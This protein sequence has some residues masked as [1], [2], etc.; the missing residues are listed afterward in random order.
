MDIKS[1][2]ESLERVDAIE[3]LLTF[4][5][6][7]GPSNFISN[8]LE[9][10]SRFSEGR[11]AFYNSDYE[12]AA[13][14]FH[15]LDEGLPGHDW[16]LTPAKINETFSWLR[17][18]KFTEYVQQYEPLATQNKVYGVILWN[19]A[20]AYCRLE[21]MDKAEECLKKWL[22]SSSPP[23]LGKGYLLL[24]ILQ[25]HNGKID[26][27]ISSFHTALKV[28]KLFCIQA[29]ERHLGPETAEAVPEAETTLREPTKIEPQIVAKDEVL[30]ALQEFL[31]PRAPGK[32][33]QVAQQLSE[34]EYQSGYVAALE[35]FG[36]GDI[37]EALR[38]IDSLIKG[39]RERGA[40]FWAKAACLLAKREW[41]DSIALIEDQ[42]GD[43]DISEGV[44]WN[45]TC[46]YF[47]LGK[48][49]LALRTITKCT[50][51]VYRTS[52]WAWLIQGLLAHL[53][54]EGGLR[55]D[56]LKEAIKISPKQLV[57]YVGLLKQIGSDLEGLP[58][59]EEPQILGV[60][61]EHLVTKYD[62]IAKNARILLNKGKNLEA[63]KEFVQLSPESTADIPEIGD[64]TFKPVILP[65]CPAEL[66]D[67]RDIF[68]FGVAAFQRKAYE[69][70][71]QRFED[72][73]LKTDRSYPAAVNLA[74]S[75]II[76][77]RYSRAIDILLDAIKRREH[78]GGYAIR[79]LISAF[80]RSGK[81]EDAFSWFSKLLE[82][83]A[84][85][86]FNF[87]QMA[88]VAQLLG[89]KE[90]VA[91]VLFNA[92]T[93]NLAEPSIRLKGAAVRACLD[94][95]DHD[96]A[97]ALVKFFVKETP[98][99][100]V[101]AG[102]TRP[103]MPA[104]DCK[105][106]LQMNRQYAIF[107]R[108]RDARAALAYF[109]EV[110]SA[111][112]AD[113]G[114]SIDAETADALFNACM[115]YGRGL[116]WNKEFE[117]A[118]EIL[119]QAFSILSDHS[120]YYSPRE[121]SK[122]YSALT[123]VYVQRR[124]YFWALE[125]CE[126][127]LEA[128]SKNKGLLKLR[129][130]IKQ[131]IEEIPERSREAMKELAELS[132][133]T[134]EKTADYIGV[135]PKV[136][137]LIQTLPQDF[138]ASRKV[139]AELSD[140][141]NAVISLESVPIIDKKKEIMRQ[142]EVIVRI[143]RDLPLYLPRAF[144][145]ALI[146]ILKGMKKTLVEV[147]AKSICPEF[148]LAL[149]PVSYYRESEASLVFKLRNIGAT[150]MNRLRIKVESAPQET[151]APVIEEQSFEII[152]KDELLWI[153]WP[154]HF[155]SFSEP[156]S[157]IK[158][159]IS[160]CF[161]GGSLRG[162]LVDQVIDDQATTLMPFIDLSVDYPV[163]ALRPE[164]NNKLYGRENLLRT[165]KNSFTRS[166]QT[167]IPFLEGVRKVGKTSILYF[168]ANRLT[169]SSLPV[170]VNLDTSW[171]NP[172]QLLAKRISDEFALK[173]SLELG[174]LGQIVCKDDFDRFLSNAIRKTGVKHIVLL[175]DE[176]HTAIDRIEKG[177]L[178]NEFLGDLRY[179]YMD[180]QQQISVAFAD[181]YL[182][183]EL[184]SRVPAQ[185]WTDFAREP[186]SF[187]NELDTREAILFPAQDSPVRFERD[188]VS[189]IYY[190]TNGYPWHI[191][192]ICSELINHL[193]TQK[194]YV[195]IPQDVDLIVQKL[196]REDRLF[197][198]GVC[199][200]ERLSVNSQH[201][202]YG[203][204]EAIKGLKGDICTWFNREDIDNMG[205]P[206]DFKREIG[207]LIQ[208]EVL[209]ERDSQLRFCSPLHAMWFEAKRQKGADI[210]GD[211]LGEHFEGEQ[212]PS[213]M[214]IP[215]DPSSEI[216]QKC[217]SLK[218]LK[219]QL[220]HA[221]DDEHQIFKNVEMP[222]EWENACIVV[223][224]RDSWNVFIKALRD[225]FLED[226]KSRLGSWEDSKRYTDLNREM[227]SIRKRRNYVE[228]PES[229]EGRNEEEKCCLKDIG[230]RIP[231]SQNDWLI[232]Q[233]KALD[234]LTKVFEAIIE[235]I[236]RT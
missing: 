24:S 107:N 181:W 221:L 74:A 178:P 183:D 185:L 164:E 143:E 32:Y 106:Y 58:S 150:D 175:L 40:L 219:S 152:K 147:Q 97:D 199:R 63:A 30:S 208:L 229:E 38:I 236:A 99:P 161:T 39:S 70:A 61:D 84:R 126:R 217:D 52:P 64:T 148:T 201:L 127:G 167:R 157:T 46:A 112:E 193:N 224:T 177:T 36:D 69:E 159:N 205:L 109:Q 92:C 192:W 210:H 66:Y 8:N 140:L 154:I 211:L 162:E 207:R 68:L 83:S 214:P 57:Y 187:L 115:F 231:T 72:L 37:D 14:I 31:I 94:V 35:K 49:E 27:A 10:S 120:N 33:P 227:H 165:L 78:G 228:H 81:A 117:K 139:I 75:L 118:H 235:Q 191:Q 18:G 73:Y 23:F 209:Q 21:K 123:N 6:V 158:L 146:P 119:R 85:E 155:D 22:E 133:S 223:R 137:Q 110:Y 34:F 87:V 220:R 128:D 172:Y 174:E 4:A 56:A 5:P 233:L 204:L 138:P 232:L 163:V 176:F 212:M 102:V 122:R 77:E 17:L 125:L 3:D 116:F 156:E 169:N 86:Y 29:I 60:E 171:T 105:R 59:E 19:L 124:H 71:V 225:L 51:G 100:Y 149:E 55:T 186:I 26:D 200:P 41:K 103:I 206:F 180:Q 67:Y 2:L 7:V 104:S 114:A 213:T 230:K 151:W 196:L 25:F 47:N 131:K 190:W 170:Y 130:E 144:I 188:V 48:Y 50:E 88:Y 42:L 113:Y 101:V 16:F 54:G 1:I 95:K 234:R 62:D 166:G 53:C 44:L 203:V 129:S 194:R 215:E 20:V 218:N 96:R 28:D 9:W 13:Q 136:S 189:R 90:D 98:L 198:E 93:I 222:E 182:I 179:M 184:K 108:S 141:T 80:M 197:N 142:R 12:R 82:T 45:A 160:L 216:H 111:R 226:L 135:L 145:S 79:N 89:R 121:L 153:D 15:E 168:L 134:A 132:L 91:T 11:T 43:L 76:T 202:I 195:A 65:T 173:M